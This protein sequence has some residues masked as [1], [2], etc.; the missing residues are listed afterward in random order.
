MK[1]IKKQQVSPANA[2]PIKKLVH[3]N[4]A[5]VDPARSIRNIHASAI[6]YDQ[7]PF[8]PRAYVIMKDA[9]KKPRGEFIPTS[10]RVTFDHGEDMQRRLNQD[11]LRKEMV[12]NWKCV[13]C[14]KKQTFTRRPTSKSCVFG[15]TSIRCQ[16]EYHEV[17]I[18]NDQT[19]IVGSIDAFINIGKP[20]LRMV[21]VKTM[22]KEQFT[23][24]IAPLAEHSLRTKLYLKLIADSSQKFTKRVD[25]QTASVFYM[26]KGFGLKDDT[27]KEMGIK[28]APFSPFKEWE[29][30]RD[31]ALILPLLSK[32]KSVEV[33][34]DTGKVPCRICSTAFDPQAKKCSVVKLCFGSKYAQDTTWEE[35]G[36]KAFHTGKEIVKYEE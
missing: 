21:E 18:K 16:W 14:G 25:T 3:S 30:K 6:T 26:V 31:D 5:K 34:K 4:I 33:W 19:G 36:L 10:L 22:V 1:F 2:Q 27:L 12:G 28:D 15:S 7:K 9:H 11:Y 23:K 35:A 13:S 17:I 20:I 24:L 32:A 8:C 29:V